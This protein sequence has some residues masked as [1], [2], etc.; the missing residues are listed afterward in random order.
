MGE[1]SAVQRGKLS[2][3]G[4]HL[5]DAATLLHEVAESNSETDV[6]IVEQAVEKVKEWVWWLTH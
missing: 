4:Q 3:A 6:R 2:D 1:L 5:Q